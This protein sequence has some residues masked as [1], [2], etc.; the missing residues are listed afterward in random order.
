MSLIPF[1]GLRHKNYIIFL[2]Q[3]KKNLTASDC[4]GTSHLKATLSRRHVT[5]RTEQEIK[6]WV[7]AMVLVPIVFVLKRPN[8]T[9]TTTT[10]QP[11]LKTTPVLI[12]DGRAHTSSHVAH[13]SFARCR[14]IF[15]FKTHI[16][17]VF[18]R[19]QHVN[20][21]EWEPELGL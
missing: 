19:S 9:V 6:C 16:K 10:N 4:Q 8:P 3:K 20:L 2:R 21:P 1:R 17:P 12:P 18:W 11:L 7:V 5:C 13:C 15:S 14:D